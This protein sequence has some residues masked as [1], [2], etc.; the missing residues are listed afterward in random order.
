MDKSK[1]KQLVANTIVKYRDKYNDST[2]ESYGYKT[3]YSVQHCYADTDRNRW[4]CL[5]HPPQAHTHSPNVI[6]C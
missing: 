5:E 6:L 4:E 3:Q 2:I 1:T